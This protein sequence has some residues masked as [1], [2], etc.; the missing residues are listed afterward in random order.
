[1]LISDFIFHFLVYDIH[2]Y[3]HFSYVCGQMNMCGMNICMHALMHVCGG[4]RLVVERFVY[5]SSTLFTETVSLS[6]N[7]R[8]PIWFISI[9]SLIWGS[10]VSLF[11]DCNYR[12]TCISMWH[13]HGVLGYKLESLCLQGKCMHCWAVFPARWNSVLKPDSYSSHE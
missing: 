13:L 11:Q 10:L 1:M 2:A 12:Q 4:L 8:L 5:H 9:T 7:N 3:V 6:Q